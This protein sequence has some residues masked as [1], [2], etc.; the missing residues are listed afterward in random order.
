MLLGARAESAVNARPDAA[1]AH[2]A[3]GRIEPSAGVIVERTDATAPQRLQV[4]IRY[5]DDDDQTDSDR[6]KGKR[7][8]K[9]RPQ[10]W[11]EELTLTVRG[12]EILA[13]IR[14][15]RHPPLDSLALQFDDQCVAWNR[16]FDVKRAGQRIAAPHDPR[17]ALRPSAT[18]ISNKPSLNFIVM[19]PCTFFAAARRL[20]LARRFNAG[21]V[22]NHSPRRVA[23]PEFNR[24]NEMQWSMRHFP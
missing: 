4:R 22:G 13:H 17:Q 7:R 5:K 21:N 24:R 9:F 1:P 14:P 3:H 11:S 6:Q 15:G 2:V 19:P 8:L 12:G 16:P 23:T 20:I 18:S 10:H